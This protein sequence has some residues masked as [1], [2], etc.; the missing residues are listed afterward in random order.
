MALA[1]DR[2]TLRRS[3]DRVALPIAAD[4]VIFHHA[5]VVM[6]S[7]GYA[8]PGR[9]S[10]TDK[11]IGRA[12]FSYDNSG[13]SAGDLTVEIETGVFR[14][15]NS[16]SGDAITMAAHRDA[17]VYVVDDETVAATSNSGAR[18]PAGRVFDVDSDGVWVVMGD[19]ASAGVSADYPGGSFTPT[20]T[21][22]ANCASAG[23]PVG[24]YSRVGNV[25]QFTILVPDVVCAAGAP[26]ASAFDLS[27]PIASDFAAA[28]DLVGVVTGENTTSGKA[29]ADVTN[30]RIDVTFAAIG[31]AASNDIVVSG[32][33]TVI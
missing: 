18:V 24:R 32:H 16:S 22:G 30:N 31:G 8:R 28:T 19:A 20:F 17:V 1:Q 27:I 2:N 10:T 23:T 3:G 26:T 25:V 12:M 9:A 14:W 7:S 11:A 5:L 33:Y 6:D 4:V 21:A 15:K 29:S 13:G